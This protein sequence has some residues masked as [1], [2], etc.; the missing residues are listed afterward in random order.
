[1]SLR[2]PTSAYFPAFLSAITSNTSRVLE[3]RQ[4]ITG[5]IVVGEELI[6]GAWARYLRADHSFLGGLWIGPALTALTDPE[7]ERLLE[8]EKE[9]LAISRAE[10]IY[11][12]SL[13]SSI[14]GAG[15]DSRGQSTF[16][17]QEIVRLGRLSEEQLRGN[18]RALI[19]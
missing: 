3:S 19:M 11:V 2:Y 16:I 8:A 9:A 4:S 13:R 18:E 17:L 15:A 6:D 12:R 14:L 7:E 5:Q 10:S 1:V